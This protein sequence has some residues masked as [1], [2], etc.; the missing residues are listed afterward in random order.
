MIEALEIFTGL[1]NA[2]IKKL[3]QTDFFS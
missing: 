1:K 3:S 2:G